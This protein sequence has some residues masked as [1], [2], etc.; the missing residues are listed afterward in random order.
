M[1]NAYM[2]RNDGKE[3]PVKVHP[4]GNPEVIEETLYAS[5]WLYQNTKNQKVQEAF[6]GQSA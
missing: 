1:Y 5:Q 3:I 6:C 4:Y 2:I